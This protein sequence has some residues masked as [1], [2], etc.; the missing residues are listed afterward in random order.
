MFWNVSLHV[1]LKYKF[2]FAYRFVLNVFF[3]RVVSHIFTSFAF[4]KY[5]PNLNGWRPN[6][7]N[8]NIPL[9]IGE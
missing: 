2:E 3:V 8:N 1:L 4:S 7:N 6:I 9:Q 5:K